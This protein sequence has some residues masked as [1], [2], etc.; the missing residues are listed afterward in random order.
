LIC[1]NF[2]AK[3]FNPLK[4]IQKDLNLSLHF[5]HLV[6]KISF[7]LNLKSVGS[8]T[9]NFYFQNI[10]KLVLNLIPFWLEF[11]FIE[12]NSQNSKFHFLQPEILLVHQLF[13]FARPKSMSS[14]IFHPC[15][16]TS[17]CGPPAPFSSCLLPPDRAGSRDR[18]LSVA[19]ALHAPPVDAPS[20]PL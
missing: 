13:S 11:K 15:Q 18:P 7:G 2:Q 17:R 12:S 5:K 14:L 9:E 16:P 3:D 20:A 10:P 19:T 1:E 4:I 6:F 8:K